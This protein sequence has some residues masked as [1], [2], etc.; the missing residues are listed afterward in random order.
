MGSG[1]ERRPLCVFELS[2]FEARGEEGEKKK[3]EM[4]G[5]SIGIKELLSL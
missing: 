1:E 5:E 2:A 4:S 3:R